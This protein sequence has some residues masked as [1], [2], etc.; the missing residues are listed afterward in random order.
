MLDNNLL[1][2]K[3]RELV[4]G[5]SQFLEKKIDDR[6]GFS[7]RS[8]YGM[9]FYLLMKIEQYNDID[10]VELVKLIDL[11]KDNDF[12]DKTYHWEF[13]RFALAASKERLSCEK[14]KV[15]DKV[16]EYKKFRYTRV[17]N[18]MMLRA[19]ARIVEG[20]WIK[21]KI[22]LLE[23]HICLSLFQTKDGFIEDRR[24]SPTI[25]YHC[26]ASAI[27]GLLLVRGYINGGYLKSKFLKAVNIISY[28]TSKSGE[29]NYLGRGKFQSFGY[30][31]SIM[32]LSSAYA[33]TG[34]ESY[35]DL[36]KR[37][38]K[39]LCSYIRSDGSLP[40]VLRKEEVLR[41][42]SFSLNNEDYLGWYSY[43]NYYDYL[44]FTG[45]LLAI[46]NNI[47]EQY[48][49]KKVSDLAV[50]LK[51]EENGRRVKIDETLIVEN[52]NYFSVVRP[53]I[54]DLCSQLPIP[55]IINY[56]KTMSEVFPTY[57]GEQNGMDMYPAESL[58]LPLYFF[59]SMKKC[60]VDMLHYRWVGSYAFEGVGE[61]LVHRRRFE[62]RESCIFIFDEIDII[63]E[64]ITEV[65]VNRV[66]VDK[67]NF[68]RLF[69]NELFLENGSIVFDGKIEREKNEF[70]H[71]KG[72]VL[73]FSK[74]ILVCKKRKLFSEYEI[75]LN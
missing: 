48:D 61:D 51:C 57:G 64:K 6:F 29:F 50:G 68:L 44:P 1:S 13:N 55:Y 15:L 52:K 14:K 18:W 74:S 31:S 56:K 42:G 43:N 20:G 30:A 10:E 58:P 71:S 24:K 39:Y 73:C 60:C 32:A 16:Y 72:K 28:F 27:L 70:Y 4:K 2:D 69:G 5:I 34:R 37:I 25:Q 7:D 9:P 12:E 26:F 11:I 45:A 47:I 36:L 49:G 23:I 54:G 63:N 46:S 35:L 22:G 38:Q 21:R 17:A 62:Y 67:N 53:P 3:S 19:A 75:R 33:M 8:F 41:S 65:L 40:L 59:K 66:G